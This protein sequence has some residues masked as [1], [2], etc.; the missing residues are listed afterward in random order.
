MNDRL[1][2]LKFSAIYNNRGAAKNTQC[3]DKP[4]R[5][6]AF[7]AS[8]TLSA[9]GY[10][11]PADP[12]QRRDLPLGEGRAVIQSIAQSDDMGLP[13]GEAGVHTPANLRAGVPQ[14]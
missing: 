11:A 9:A 4:L 6:K 12:A 13:P 1:Y 10:I 14:I 3:P 7:W 2:P 8:F 5:C